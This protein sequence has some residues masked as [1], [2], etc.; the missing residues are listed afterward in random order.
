M[1][2]N[3]IHNLKQIYV[4]KKIKNLRIM[5][6]K[7]LNEK[8]FNIKLFDKQFRQIIFDCRNNS[9]MSLKNENG[10]FSKYQVIYRF[11]IIYKNR[12]DLIILFFF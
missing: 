2:M 5:L 11:N 12:N 3:K 1:H 9:T 4:K 7:I 8:Y 10:E 6:K